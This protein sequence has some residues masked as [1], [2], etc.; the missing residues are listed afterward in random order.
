MKRFLPTLLCGGLCAVPA[1]AAERP[2]IILIMVDDMGYSD[3]ACYGGEIATPNIDA[4]ARQG[5]RFS[6]FYNSA[7]CCPTRASLLTGLHPHQAG[8]GHMTAEP[9]GGGHTTGPPAYQ[10]HLNQHCVTLADIAKSAGYATFMTGKWHLAGSDQADWP[11]QRGFD[12]YWGCINGAA[13]HF[14]PVPPRIMYSGNEPDLHPQST[15]DRRFYTTDAF[16]DHAIGFLREHC[17]P[18]APPPATPAPPPSPFFLYLAFTAPH[19]PIQAHDEDIAKYLGRY[20][21]GWDQLRQQRYQRQLELGLIDPKWQLS[22]RDPAVPPWDNVPP[23]RKAD[24]ALRMTVYAAMIDRI[25][26]NIGKLVAT[27]KQLDRFDNTLIL[28]LSDNGACAEG[29]V[30]PAGDFLNKEARN[31]SGGI[32]YGTGWA[33]A[34]ATPY[35]LYKHYAHEG[36]SNTPF[37]AHWPARIKPRADWFR[38]P[39]QIIDIMPTVVDLTGAT[40][41]SNLRGREIIP[42]DGI[43][44]TPAFTGAP[45]N[46][47][48][49]LFMEHENNAFIRDDDWKLVGCGVAPASGLIPAKWELYQIKTDGTELHDLAAQF[50]DKV[51]AYSEQWQ[52][53]AKRSGV[54]PKPGAAKA[55]KPSA[56][57]P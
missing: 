26:Q 51:A 13:N 55:T 54:Y 52:S 1:T 17:Q 49:P 46:R 35:R 39:A 9:P 27:L 30:F 7:R 33:N 2:D 36:G 23:E 38:Q 18:A 40:Y 21:G 57:K 20:D 11:L 42:G 8:I 45:L 41:P 32:P 19:W 24:L 44:L 15:T 37:F 43:P 4:L 25:D 3:L 6:Q 5:I 28:F 10:G 34:S 56:K 29:K 14:T 47:K 31:A 12:R 48:S 53:W 16:T 50:P 22:P